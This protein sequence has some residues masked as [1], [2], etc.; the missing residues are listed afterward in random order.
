MR[1]ARF[2]VF[3][4]MAVALALAGCSGD[5]TQTLMKDPAM[6]GK[7]MDMITQSAPMAGQ[8][9]DKML[10]N[11]Q[12]KQMIMDKV[13]G[14]TE[15]MNGVVSKIA[16]NPDMVTSVL[17]VAVKDDATKAKVMDWMKTMSAQSKMAKK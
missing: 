5:M 8:M 2:H 14:S 15:L 11:D 1:L 17:D 7:I 13:M 16:S 4:V 6:Q 10:A 3:V 12:T 9:V